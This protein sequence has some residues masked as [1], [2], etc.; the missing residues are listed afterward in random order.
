MSRAVLEEQFVV[1]PPRAPSRLAEPSWS[2]APVATDAPQVR[3]PAALGATGARR[4][5]VAETMRAVRDAVL[6]TLRAV[7]AVL[8]IAVASLTVAALMFVQ[9]VLHLG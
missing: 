6:W 9:R 2:A 7:G 4:R 5:G 1:L 8:G 3:A